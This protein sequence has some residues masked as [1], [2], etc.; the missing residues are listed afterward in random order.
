[1]KCIILQQPRSWHDVT[2]RVLDGAV[3]AFTEVLDGVQR[4]LLLSL[5]HLHPAA[6]TSTAA[7]ATQRP[8]LT[9]NLICKQQCLS[10]L[11]GMNY[12]V[13]ICIALY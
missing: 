13:Y 5:L 7:F 3:E 11:S 6:A 12:K 10:A 2:Y 9:P 8:I 1:M 4:L